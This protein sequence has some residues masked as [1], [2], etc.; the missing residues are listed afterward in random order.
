MLKG[1]CLGDSTC[2]CLSVRNNGFSSPGF[3]SSEKPF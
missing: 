2:V 3:N 1:N